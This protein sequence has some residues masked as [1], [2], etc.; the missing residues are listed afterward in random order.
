MIPLKFSQPVN[1]TTVLRNAWYRTQPRS[2]KR[3]NTHP[4]EEQTINRNGLEERTLSHLSLTIPPASWRDL[5]FNLFQSE[6]ESD[7]A[8]RCKEKTHIPSMPYAHTPEV[9]TI[10]R[11]CGD[12]APLARATRSTKGKDIGNQ[13]NHMQPFG[14][15]AFMSC[16]W[17][18]WVMSSQDLS[19]PPLLINLLLP[20]KKNAI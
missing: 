8:R 18:S 19:T 14:A 1:P 4:R 7:L 9:T 12:E 20:P 15:Q 11:H 13:R 3:S 6:N 2:H 5:K 16:D 17:A 10:N